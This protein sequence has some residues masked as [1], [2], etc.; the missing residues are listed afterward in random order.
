M[1]Q[2]A[3]VDGEMSYDDFLRMMRDVSKEDSVPAPYV[4]VSK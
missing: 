2:E 3:D 1:M 4:H